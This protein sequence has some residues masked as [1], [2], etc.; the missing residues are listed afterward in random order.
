MANVPLPKISTVP[1]PQHP[2]LIAR[3]SEDSL[4]SETGSLGGESTATAA[5]S[6]PCTPTRLLFVSESIDALSKPTSLE[7]LTRLR[8]AAK[9]LDLESQRL[10]RHKGQD[11]ASIRR[12]PRKAVPQITEAELA[13]PPAPRRAAVRHSLIAPP[14]YSFLVDPEPPKDHPFVAQATTLAEAR[15]IAKLK[16]QAADGLGAIVAPPQS[17]AAR[18]QAFYSQGKAAQSV[19]E[20]SPRK[21]TAWTPPPFLVA[22]D[23][24]R[25]AP[26]PACRTPASPAVPGP[27]VMALPLPVPS[28]VAAAAELAA[29]PV[30]PIPAEPAP[31]TPTRK[32]STSFLKHKKISRLFGKAAA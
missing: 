24:A 14:G 21:N 15:A 17:A 13:A 7:E 22:R 12:V 10:R 26:K 5:S 27:P 32:A 6:S 19:I 4:A 8:A 31:Q 30:P 16:S 18:R 28:P 23:A 11:P 3:G 25:E 20:F 2:E 29:I 9:Q 1:P